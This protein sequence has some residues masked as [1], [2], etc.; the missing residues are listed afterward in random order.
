MAASPEPCEEDDEVGSEEAEDYEG[1][2]YVEVGGGSEELEPRGPT[3]GDSSD[4]EQV[5]RDQELLQPACLAVSGPPLPPGAEAP[6]DADEYLRNV[7]WERMHVP[8][9]VVAEVDE[10]ASQRRKRAGL[11]NRHGHLLTRFSEPEVPESA[12]RCAE[13]A[14]D[15]A[16]AFSAL[17]GRCESARSS[18]S[19]P[20]RSSRL[21][22]EAW[23]ERCAA[24]GPSTAFL[25]AQDFVS[26]NNLVVVSVGNLVAAQEGLAEAPAGTP[27][28]GDAGDP[29][30]AGHL[31]SLMEWVFAAL[32][33]VEEPLVDDIQYQLQRLRRACQK[34]S[35]AAC[36]EGADMD[37]GT[38]ARASL[39]Q[40][41]V[42]DV[43][44][45]R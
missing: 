32:A 16:E 14:S 17:R 7:Q 42:A 33:F 44:G 29:L 43:F 11:V 5:D 39:L 1:E 28:G 15:A 45:Q 35:V 12:R 6:R 26:L 21:T 27:G 41:V 37:A 30:P 24:G 31:D 36:G 2:E 10:Q 23:H 3:G 40:V 13:W 38:H 4:D 22:F 34:I 25:A 9:T 20:Q 18:A 19:A 8:E